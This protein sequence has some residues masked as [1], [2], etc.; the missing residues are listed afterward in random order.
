M[1]YNAFPYSVAVA[2]VVGGDSKVIIVTTRVDCD[3]TK[4]LF[5]SHY[6]VLINVRRQRSIR[7]NTSYSSVRHNVSDGSSLYIAL[8]FNQPHSLQLQR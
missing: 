1:C 2:V 4:R 7:N 3:S 5:R 8:V 6:Y